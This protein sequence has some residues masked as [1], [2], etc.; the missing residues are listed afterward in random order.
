MD[1]NDGAQIAAFVQRRGDIDDELATADKI[2]TDKWFNLYIELALLA[3]CWGPEDA[4]GVSRIN[5]GVRVEEAEA[6]LRFA[7]LKHL[8]AL[9][10]V[11]VGP[12]GGP[13]LLIHPNT[14]AGFMS[15]SAVGGFRRRVP[16]RRC[17]TCTSWY[18][19]RRAGNLYCS[20]ACRV[21]HSVANRKKD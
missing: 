19:L 1:S 2:C 11:S 17:R 6:W 10:S 5:A 15:L 9:I 7:G 3:R 12:P 8:T 4:D 20:P 13:D 18:E 21:A 14:L 16:M